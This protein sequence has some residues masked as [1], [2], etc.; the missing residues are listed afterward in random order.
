MKRALNR[1][2]HVDMAQRDGA[3]SIAIDA[4]V[5]F[6]RKTADMANAVGRRQRE[7]IQR[8]LSSLA[9]SSARMTQHGKDGRRRSL[10]N[11]ADDLKAMPL[12]KRPVACSSDV[13]DR[14]DIPPGEIF[15]I[16]RRP[17]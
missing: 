11:R 3:C 9:P 10:L 17:E 15:F 14:S 5:R 7:R 8:T 2:D 16:R 6:L 12:V 4:G 13:S 1:G